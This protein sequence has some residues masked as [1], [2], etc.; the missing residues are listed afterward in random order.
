MAMLPKAMLSEIRAELG[1]S[2]DGVVTSTQSAVA[3]TGY[4]CGIAGAPG[5]NDSRLFVFD[6]RTEKARMAPAMDD[7][8]TLDDAFD[9]VEFMD[10]YKRCDQ[11]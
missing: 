2:A 7:D 6:V 3:R 1:D 9:G 11:G 5:A 4:L 8:A 10:V